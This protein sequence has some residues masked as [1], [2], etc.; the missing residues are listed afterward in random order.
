[1]G[2][3]SIEKTKREKRGFFTGMFSGLS[4]LIFSVFQLVIAS[5]LIGGFVEYRLYQNEQR[6]LQTLNLLERF[7]LGAV[8]DAQRK[9]TSTLR[10]TEP[11]IKDLQNA[12]LSPEA[13]DRSRRQLIE[14][15]IYDSNNGDGVWREL[16]TM[17]LFIDQIS[18]CVQKNVCDASLSDELF[19]DY[20]QTLFEN[21]GDYVSEKR[22]YAPS[23]ALK[24]E[25]FVK[26]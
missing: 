5:S 22:Q 11:A 25:A 15:V 3:M 2:R 16:D 26:R 6:V 10:Q 9:I 24:A 18:I 13:A 4:K 12:N 21:F 17:F 23:Y 19:L 14:F 8:G 1:M 20:S 7:Q